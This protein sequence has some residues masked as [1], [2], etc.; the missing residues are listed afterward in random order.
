MSLLY[1]GDYK[2]S[3]N[4]SDR[5]RSSSLRMILLVCSAKLKVKIYSRVS[6]S[7]MG[8]GMLK[9][10]LPCEAEYAQDEQSTPCR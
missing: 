10:H 3:F 9:H 1:Y 7:P 6:K 2:F 8:G 5:N 4:E